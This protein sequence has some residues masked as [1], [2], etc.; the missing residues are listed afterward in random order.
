MHILDHQGILVVPV[1]DLVHD[2]HLVLS[3]C[4]RGHKVISVELVQLS[5]NSK[6]ALNDVKEPGDK[7]RDCDDGKEKSGDAANGGG[8]GVL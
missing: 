2:V 5:K 7:E 1:H 3:H 8:V 6:I 4:L